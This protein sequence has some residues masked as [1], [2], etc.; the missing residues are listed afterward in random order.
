MY[1]YTKYIHVFTRNMTIAVEPLVGNTLASTLMFSL[2]RNSH[3]MLFVMYKFDCLTTRIEIVDHMAISLSS[4][5]DY[6]R[7]DLYTK[8]CQHLGKYL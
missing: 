7:Y 3:C 2:D 4:S 6:H 8:W 5:L 1:Y